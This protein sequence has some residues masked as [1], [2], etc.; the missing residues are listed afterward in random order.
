MFIAG[1]LCQHAPPRCPLAPGARRSMPDTSRTTGAA[2]PL[3]ILVLFHPRSEQ[4]RE[5]AGVIY[6]RFMV[7]AGSPGL[8]IPVQFGAEQPDGRA[9]PSPKLDERTP[10]LVVAL[11]DDWMTQRALPA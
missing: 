6:R 11:I 2:P 1:E 4:A 9:P 10:T 3:R 8:R 7:L 5:L